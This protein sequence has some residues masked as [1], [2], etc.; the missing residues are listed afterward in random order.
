[1]NKEPL[2]KLLNQ[3]LQEASLTLEIIC[4][5]GFVLEYYGIRATQDVDAFYEETDKIHNIIEQVGKQYGINQQDEAWL[6]NSVKNMNKRPPLSLCELM[7]S[8][9]NLTVYMAPLEY[10]LGMK[11]MSARKQDIQDIG[12][13]IKSRN[14]ESPI[15]LCE[16][17]KSFGFDSV[18]I[19]VLL[20]GF[21][22]A[23]GM[24]WLENY[25][26]NNQNELISYY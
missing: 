24:E 3:K 20:E 6:N 13:I 16:K 22:N 23:Y 2:F 15:L 18:D 1:M 21:G 9:E 8:F 12:E 5:G 7:Y 19:S 4:V 14:L 10:I 26:K 11:M 17:L 25:I